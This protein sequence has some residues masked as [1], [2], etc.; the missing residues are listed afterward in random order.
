MGYDDPDEPDRSVFTVREQSL[1]TMRHQKGR[2]NYLCLQWSGAAS[3]YIWR[4]LSSNQAREWSV[5]LTARFQEEKENGIRTSML[6]PGLTDT[7]ARPATSSAN[8][9]RSDGKISTTTGCRRCVSIGCFPTSAGLCP[10]ISDAAFGF[11]V[12]QNH[13]VIQS[14]TENGQE[15]SPLFLFFLIFHSNTPLCSRG[16]TRQDSS[17]FQPTP[18]VSASASWDQVTLSYT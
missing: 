13:A 7:P 11:S 10:R 14:K 15:N 17:K 3:R 12:V 6:F 16:S 9:T 18:P 1:P 2:L 4:L 8:P 5:S